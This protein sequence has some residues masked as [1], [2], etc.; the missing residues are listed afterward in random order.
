M[1]GIVG[2]LAY[3][4]LA[5]AL[6]APVELM[7]DA[8]AHRGP[9]GRGVETHGRDLCLGAVRLAVV[10]PH[11]SHQPLHDSTGELS[12]VFNGEIYNFR[13]LR[14]ELKR[15]G[16]RFTTDG[17]GEV[18]FGLYREDPRGFA[19]RLDGM[20]AFALWDRTRRRLLLCRDRLGIK[21]LL[22]WDDGRRLIFASEAKGLLAHPA[23][24][25]GIDRA[26]IVDYLRYRFPMPSASAFAGVRKLPP[27]TCLTV[28]PSGGGRYTRRDTFWNAAAI[29]GSA[30][31]GSALGPVLERSLASTVAGLDPPAMFLSGGL[32]SSTI[33]ALTAARSPLGESFSVGYG[34]GG[35]EDE[36]PHARAVA[37][38]LGL[39]HHETAIRPQDV[40][41]LLEEVVW[42]LE[43]P[44]YTPVTLSTYAVSALA[45]R[46]HKVVLSG[47]GAD[48]L[49]LG[50][51]HFREVQALAD[52][53][54]PWEAQYWQ[55]LGWLST[56]AFDQIVGADVR[57][58][59]PGLETLTA[60][61]PVP[62][63]TA[64]RM[65][66]FEVHNKLT[67]YHLNRVDRLAM[68]HGLEVRVPYLRN[69]VVS[70]ALS[71]AATTLLG[72]Q[73][74]KQPLREV[75]A[76]RLPPGIL[77]RPKQKFTAPSVLWLSG[78]LRP[79]VKELLLD[80]DGYEAL[81][82]RRNGLRWL[83]GW[84]DAEPERAAAAVWGMVV[85]LQWYELVY[86]R[87]RQWRVVPP[88]ALVHAER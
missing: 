67:E 26:A 29:V 69:E 24:P 66:W 72:P 40:P 21:P 70:W 74:A 25:V 38:E 16:H 80:S 39:D 7:L 52:A 35:W 13:E 49:L 57:R 18:I 11:G 1:C 88:R 86:Q 41:T 84:F 12:L 28:E 47:D 55:A 63:T 30:D 44:V 87:I 8:V 82:L 6:A 50:Y 81:G 31:G 71:H 15:H 43:E 60:R 64:D 17:D 22:Y 10:D 61:C 68:A 77:G 59:A 75:A 79:L 76:T 83:A 9:D 20:F 4:E 58:A 23:V 36:R 85:L 73:P 34:H 42:H 2:V 48:E 14:A 27:G 54:G 62:A 65:R 53:G 78:S 37:A 45:A 33:C 19:G 32:D 5:P 3:D 56:E 46:R 51:A